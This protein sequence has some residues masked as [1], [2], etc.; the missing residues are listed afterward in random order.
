VLRE[1]SKPTTD[2]KYP[3]AMRSQAW[4]MKSLN[5]QLASWSQ[6]RHD[7]ILYVK[8]SYTGG[9]GCEYPNGFVEPIPHF[10]ARLE[11][12]A[13]KAADLIDKTEYPGALA[14]TK[15]KQV[16]FLKNFAK[17]T[18]TCKDIAEKELAQKELSKEETTFLK[19]IVQ[20]QRGSGFTR[21]NGWYPKLFY[22]GP[23]DCGKWDAIVAD[24]HTDVPAPVLGD[25]GCVLI[26]GIGNV[27]LMMI[28]VDNGKD[29]MVYAGP[30]LSHYEFEMP[31]VTRK[32][33]S[34][35]REDINKGKLPARTPWTKSYLV[36]GENPAAKWYRYVPD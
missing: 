30:V 20:V 32:S 29:R 27:E 23:Q 14:A 9:A 36:P 24:V 34:E 11:L 16:D 18:A 3:E 22:K 4:G 21:Y 1:L 6:L 25:P 35:W 12:M 15:K 26:Q 33:D 19:D 31:G 8:Q 2:D 28:A 5:T 13:T 7:T 17:Q 10:W